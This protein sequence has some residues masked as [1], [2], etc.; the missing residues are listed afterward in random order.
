MTEL[1]AR[2]GYL[3]ALL[4]VVTRPSAAEEGRSHDLAGYQAAVSAPSQDA[5]T[6]L[7]L[8]AASSVFSHLKT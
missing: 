4:R 8:P 1:N 6:I 2:G 7:R 3:R 5:T